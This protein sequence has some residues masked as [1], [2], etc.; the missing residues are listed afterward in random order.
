VQ[1]AV[2]LVQLAD[3]ALPEAGRVS[4]V[5]PEEPEDAVLSACDWSTNQAAL[6]R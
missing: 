5:V 2:G 4:L 6:G 1:P 3:E